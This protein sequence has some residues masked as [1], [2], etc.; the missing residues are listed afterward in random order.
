MG[1]HRP[2]ICENCSKS[3][4]PTSS[5]SQKTCSREC[6]WELHHRNNPPRP[7]KAKPPRV[8][9]C[10]TCGA[11]V[12][13]SGTAQK[14]CQPACR[15]SSKPTVFMISGAI[16]E[17]MPMYRAGTFTERLLSRY[18]VDA[19]SGCWHWIGTMMK[20]SGYG[21]I[22]RSGRNVPAHVAIWEL[23]R[24][25]IPEGLELDHLCR[26]RRCV[27]PMH[28]ELVTRAENIRRSMEHVGPT[29]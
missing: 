2:R 22:G 3:F 17:T 24:G 28:L 1:N 10:P 29:V 4:V 15:P 16:G 13:A 21:Q 19:Y 9:T 14:Y 11:S 5:A 20:T 27:N 25:A 12:I 7:P 8:V 18:E 6:R 26:N 23:K